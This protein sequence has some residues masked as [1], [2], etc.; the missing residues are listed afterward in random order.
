M[1]RFPCD[2]QLFGA[3][4]PRSPVVVVRIGHEVGHCRHKDVDGDDGGGD[5][6]DQVGVEAEDETAV[7]GIWADGV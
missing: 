6:E 4:T 7:S 3:V 2:G 1:E 5:E